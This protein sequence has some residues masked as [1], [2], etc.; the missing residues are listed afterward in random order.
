M[1]KKMNDILHRYLDSKSVWDT[2]SKIDCNEHK[3]KV[4]KFDYLS[5]SWA[6]AT[7]MEHYPQATYE[8]HEPRIQADGT[9]MVYCTVKIE[10][11]SRFMWLPVMDYKNKAVVS[12][13]ARQINDS[14]MRCL[15]KCLAM[16]GLGHYIYAG[17][18]I[19][20][21]DKDKESAKES[22]KEPN[23]NQV[24]KRHTKN[25]V[26]DTVAGDIE[27]LKASLGNVKGE[28]GVEK[29]GQTI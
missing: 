7:L 4:G 20:S 10:E 14:M 29:L 16:Y 15:V 6:W 18:D 11:Q 25:E 9:A 28:D 5:W 27:K 26:K 17:E 19:P 21:A 13:D 2:L 22:K 12:P 8:F 1:E 23:E 3:Q 24:P